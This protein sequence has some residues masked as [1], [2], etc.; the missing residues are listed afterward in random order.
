MFF[1]ETLQIMMCVEPVDMRK[2]YHG[3]EGLVRDYIG[4]DPV[5][6]GTLFVFFGKR[7]DS[8]K[9]FYWHGNGYAIWS[10]RL[11]R[12]VFRFPRQATG[13][14]A[15]QISKTALR[16]LLDGLDLSVAA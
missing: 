13:N 4:A 11:Q 14:G 15:V 2:G 1:P 6:S 8:V 12:G 7:R 5:L 10:K 9:I 16:M 3:L